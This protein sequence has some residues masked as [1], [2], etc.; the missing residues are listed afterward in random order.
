MS[1][2]LTILGLTA[3]AG[4]DLPNRAIPYLLFNWFYAY[5]I[6]S[7]RPAKRLL[8]IDHNV[9]PREDLQV[10]GEAAVQAGKITRRQLNRLKRQEAAHANAVEGFPLFVAAGA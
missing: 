4:H 5:G 1:S 3:P 6:L 7:T 10:Y 8:R 9:A 2:L